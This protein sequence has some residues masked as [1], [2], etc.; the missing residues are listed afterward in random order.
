MTPSQVALQV[1]QYV[2]SLGTMIVTG[3]VERVN[4]ARNGVLFFALRD[5]DGAMLQ[6]CGRIDDVAEDAHVTV[7]G[8]LQVFGNKSVLQVRVKSVEVLP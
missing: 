8:V 7:T 5:S 4:R 1:S 3:R 2:E 6:C